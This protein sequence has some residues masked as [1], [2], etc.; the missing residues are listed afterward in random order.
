MQTPFTTAAA[1]AR[2]RGDAVLANRFTAEGRV[3]GKLITAAL[4]AGYVVS[5]FDGEE[6]VGKKLSKKAEIMAVLFG[7]DADKLLMRDSTGNKVGS[8]LLVYGNAD[9]GS[10]LIADHTDNDE[11]LALYRAAHGED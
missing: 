3:A 8:F 11:C 7:C 6:W 2:A 1:T 10:E 9:D 5:V 4:D